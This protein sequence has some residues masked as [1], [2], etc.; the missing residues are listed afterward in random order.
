MLLSDGIVIICDLVDTAQKGDSPKMRLD[1][2]FRE[3]YGERTV[4][5]TR[6]YESRGAGEQVDMLIRIRYDKLATIG[7]YAVLS[8]TDEQFR[9]TNVQKTHYD[10]I[11]YSD[12][13]LTRLDKNY[14]LKF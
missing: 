2:L 5:I 3:Y 8:E 1:E 7:C 4:G 13:S 14:E 12:L 11:A 10:G 9:I 6:F